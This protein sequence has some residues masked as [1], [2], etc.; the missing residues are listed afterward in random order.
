MP[1]AKV[2]T[3]A[4]N[5]CS[6]SPHIVQKLRYSKVETAVD[7]QNKWHVYHTPSGPSAFNNLAAVFIYYKHTHTH[8]HFY[9][10]V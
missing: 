3:I 1:I 10:L 6:R 8:A 4:T 7:C 9:S 2:A 5:K